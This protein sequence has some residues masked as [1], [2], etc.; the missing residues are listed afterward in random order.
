[1]ITTIGIIDSYTAHN[2]ST[3]IIDLT[4]EKYIYFFV[5]MNRCDLIDTTGM[6]ALIGALKKIHASDGSL[7]LICS[8][9]RI[10]KVFRITGLNRVFCI[11]ESANA[12]LANHSSNPSRSTENQKILESDWDEISGNWLPVRIFLAESDGHR[13][14]QEAVTRLAEAMDVEV[15]YAFD[16]VVG[17]WYRELLA[18]IK[19]SESL[20][21]FE[22][23]AASATRALNNQLTNKG[24]ADIDSALAEAVSKL[25][26]SVGDRDAVIQIGSIF[27]VQHSSVIAARNLTPGELLHLERNPVL[28]KNPA[29]A[30]QHLQSL[31]EPPH[32]SQDAGMDIPSS[33]EP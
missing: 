14:V 1:V 11:H 15:V 28:L 12:A 13:E 4:A 9:E 29:A 6:G 16:P 2:L 3:V 23:Q 27:F 8:Q 5:D 7:T 10:L 24:Q 30:L 17:S 18:R 21:S 19:R 26:A 22:E 20:P 32:G 25:I 31:R 33:L